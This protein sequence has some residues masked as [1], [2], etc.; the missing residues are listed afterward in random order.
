MSNQSML[1]I[2]GGLVAGYFIAYFKYRFDVAKSRFDFKTKILREVWEA[3]LCAKT[4]AVNFDQDVLLASAEET[5]DQRLE[6]QMKEFLEAHQEAKRIVRFNCPFYPVALHDL[7]NKILIESVLHTRFVKRQSPD[8]LKDYWNNIN[9]AT[10]TLSNLSDEL[11]GGIR[12]EV[13]RP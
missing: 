3:V 10:S 9:S 11:C 4:L 7:A 8:S 1:A 6:R 12:R 2:F 5:R 13:N